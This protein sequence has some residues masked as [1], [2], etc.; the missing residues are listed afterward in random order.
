MGIGSHDYGGSDIVWDAFYKLE[1]QESQ[2]YNSVQVR[3][4]ENW[5]PAGVTVRVQGFWCWRAGEDGHS[6]SRRACLCTFPLFFC[7][8]ESLNG[9]WMLTH[10]GDGGSLLSLFI[11]MLISSLLETLSGT[12]LEIMVSQLS[13]HLS[14][15]ASKSLSLKADDGVTTVPHG[16]QES[17]ATS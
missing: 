7:S 4:P 3:R 10:M 2:W 14:T 13:G 17:I 1:N 16:S 9:L 12:H 8:M 15:A 11:Q 6:C 5:R